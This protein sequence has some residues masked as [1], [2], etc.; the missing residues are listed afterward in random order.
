M[1]KALVIL[2]LLA[3][4]AWAFDL[5][6]PPT[7]QDLEQI[8][9][10]GWSASAD[11]IEE[12]L[13]SLWKPSNFAQV[14]STQTA[15]FRQ[16]QLLAQWCRLLGTPEPA[17]LN[18]Y[19]GRRVLEDLDKE[20]SPLVI[21]PGMPLP[22]DRTGRPLPTASENLKGANVPPDILQAF[23]PDDYTPQS[24]EVARRAKQDFL[25]K[26]AGDPGFLAEFF[27]NY[28]SDDFA[29]VVL[30]RLE[31]LY[32]AHPGKWPQYRSL[33]VAFALVYDQRPPSF[34]PHHQVDPSLLVPMDES[35]ADRFAYYARA[36]DA[37]KLEHDL[38]RLSVSELK[39][40]VDA[41]VPRADLEW[42][43]KNVRARRSQFDRA[44]TAVD[45]DERRAQ[46]GIFDW[47]KDKGRYTMANIEVWG[48]ICVD[49]AY[50]ASIAGKAKGIPTL[51]FSG[52]GSDGGHA[53]FGYLRGADGKWEL[54][55]GRYLNQNYAVGQA[56]DPQ[57]W[58]PISDHELLFLSGK[59]TKS[60]GQDAALGD[61]A[62][63]GLFER[64]GDG[65]RR[66]E[67]TQSALQN[68]PAFPAAWDAREE[69][70]DAAGDNQGLRELYTAGIA[71]FQ[72]TE[73]LKVRYQA[74]LADFERSQGDAKLAGKLEQQMVT[75]NRRGRSDLS[76]AAGAESLTRLTESGDYRGALRE[77]N[78]L[79]RKLARQGGGNFFYEIVRPL[80]AELRAAGREDDAQDVIREARKRMAFEP[81]SILARE[82]DELQ[83]PAQAGDQ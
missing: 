78:S 32:T 18:A 47:P 21:P 64:K 19:L 40:V 72:G 5:S 57:T 13:A 8:R 45:Y 54:D 71:K 2:C 73:D 9:T 31:Q 60:P 23:F 81:D 62:M 7:P 49:Q 50:F 53:W 63:A 30:T 69:A 66:L 43:A 44:F 65:A 67:A 55:A 22:A 6:R 58:L 11:E 83:S 36:N 51:F 82:F 33:M 39:H 48:G 37:G 38:R 79:A 74:R 70:L 29:P 35:L 75:Q 1:A 14:G 20:R 46:R 27:R 42:A 12:Q 4:A 15:I 68:A 34:W 41:P 16:W 3:Q 76:A 24:N 56:L 77:F 25:L 10:D 52:Q 26:L 28:S 80:V 59:A 61:L 17:V